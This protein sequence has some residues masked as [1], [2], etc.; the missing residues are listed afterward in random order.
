[1]SLSLWTLLRYDKSGS[2]AYTKTDTEHVTISI[3]SLIC[4]TC[5]PQGYCNFLPEEKLLQAVEVGQVVYLK[6]CKLVE[7]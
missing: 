1:M 3:I 5:P 7:A 6:K 4:V 2:A